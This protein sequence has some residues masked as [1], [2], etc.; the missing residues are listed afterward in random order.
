M[1]HTQRPTRSITAN[2]DGET[3][4][5]R[6]F[7]TDPEYASRIEGDAGEKWLFGIDAKGV[8]S[9]L[10]TTAAAE[11]DSAIDP[12]AWVLDL[13]ADHAGVHVDELGAV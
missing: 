12:P 11:L 13:L 1:A 2:I 6:V 10:T 7:D 5:I 4:T 3:V 9:P 8:P